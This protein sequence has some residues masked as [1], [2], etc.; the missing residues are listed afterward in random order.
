MAKSSAVD[1]KAAKSKYCC[2]TGIEK[3]KI[4]TRKANSVRGFF[5]FT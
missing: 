3:T 1:L 5:I 4:I 2:Y